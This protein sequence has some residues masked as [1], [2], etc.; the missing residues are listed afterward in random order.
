VQF[1]QLNFA[2]AKINDFC[3]HLAPAAIEDNEF[4]A[5]IHA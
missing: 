2:A 5:A 1:P 4:F 3:S